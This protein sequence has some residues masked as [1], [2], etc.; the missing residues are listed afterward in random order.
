M[1]NKQRNRSQKLNHKKLPKEDPLPSGLKGL[2]RT[3]RQSLR[4]EGQIL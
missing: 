1:K 3:H 2:Q 4:R